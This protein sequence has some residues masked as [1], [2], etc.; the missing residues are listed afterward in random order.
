MAQRGQRV[1]ET[2][3]FVRTEDIQETLINLQD[4]SNT[5][6]PRLS[7]AQIAWVGAALSERQSLCKRQYGKDGT[8][9]KAVTERLKEI[10]SQ[11]DG[12]S[13]S[14]LQILHFLSRIRA[15][16]PTL[17]SLRKKPI[18]PKDSNAIVLHE[19]QLNCAKAEIKS[20]IEGLAALHVRPKILEKYRK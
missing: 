18:D 12:V 14:I 20:A 17:Q 10:E 2:H 3:E 11:L 6:L 7:D 13:P 15:I 5:A 9:D 19:M 4:A 8:I 16:V 1:P